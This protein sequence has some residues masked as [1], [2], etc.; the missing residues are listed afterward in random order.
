MVWQG[1]LVTCSP[2]PTSSSPGHWL[3]FNETRWPDRTKGN[4][5]CGSPAPGITPD[6]DSSSS[7]GARER[8]GQPGEGLPVH[9]DVLMSH[10]ELEIVDDHVGDVIHVDCVLHGVN[11]R[12]EQGRP[13]S[14]PV[15][16]EGRDG[17]SDPGK[18]M[19]RKSWKVPG[20]VL[21]GPGHIPPLHLP[22][23]TAGAASSLK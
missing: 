15:I 8:K 6:R 19:Q 18:G 13:G 20:C 17:N 12:P 3:P 16:R 22:H 5:L 1:W 4:T 11:H 2:I 9:R 23:C 7:E 14:A 21:M 10:H